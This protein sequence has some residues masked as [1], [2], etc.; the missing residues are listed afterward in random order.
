[1]KISEAFDLYKTNFL[2][3][4][5]MSTRV[6]QDNEFVKKRLIDAV[7][8]KELQEFGLD[9]ISRWATSITTYS[10]CRGE[11]VPR[12]I[13]TIRNDL[14]RLKM[15]LRYAQLRGYKT[16]NPEL[17]PIPKREDNVRPFLSAEEVSAMIDN[18][19]SVRNAFIVSLLYSSGIRLSEMISLDIDSIRNRRFTVIGKGRKARLCF[20]DKRTEK[21]MYQYLSTRTDDCQ[22]LIVSNLHHDRMTPTNVQLL[23]RNTAKRAGI[24]KKVTPHVL[25]HSFATNFISNNGNIRYLSNLLGHSNVATTMIYTHVVD[26]ELEKQYH[27]YHS[28]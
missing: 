13:N 16:L 19:W 26:N 12:K 21:L 17:V 28:I 10:N 9:D 20:I 6:L 14:S 18:A 11:I 25:R 22:A 2:I 8:D 23:I 5:G 15:V 24:H 7:G 3:I 27:L 1:M 4:K